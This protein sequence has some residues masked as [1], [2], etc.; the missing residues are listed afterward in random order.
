MVV[1]GALLLIDGDGAIVVVDDPNIPA[2]PNAEEA[3]VVLAGG[4]WIPNLNAGGVLALCEG[5]WREGDGD[6]ALQIDIGALLKNGVLDTPVGP[7]EILEVV[8]IV[9]DNDGG[10]LVIP[11]VVVTGAGKAFGFPVIIPVVDIGA[12]RA[13]APNLK[14]SCIGFEVS[15]D[16]ETPKL[17]LPGADVVLASEGEFELMPELGKPNLNVGAGVLTP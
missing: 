2:P 11:I 12:A 5:T 13:G 3:V 4:I 7:D 8:I 17:N 10:V 1:T 14:P 15:D 9:D 16:V 6:G